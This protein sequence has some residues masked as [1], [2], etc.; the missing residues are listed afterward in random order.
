MLRD[1]RRSVPGIASDNLHPNLK[2]MGEIAQEFFMK[3]SLSPNYLA[4]QQKILNGSDEIF[5]Q[6]I[7]DTV[8]AQS[9]ID[10]DI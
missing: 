8:Y 9:Q 7:K 5:N 1:T 3:M 2:G 6:V 10:A 4:R